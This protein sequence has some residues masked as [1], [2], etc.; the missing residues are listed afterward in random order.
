MLGPPS[1]GRP[2]PSTDSVLEV[3]RDRERDLLTPRAPDHLDA[4]RQ[5]LR[6]STGWNDDAWLA[7]KGERERVVE[8]RVEAFSMEVR[9]AGAGRTHD[10]IERSH[11]REHARSKAVP[12]GEQSDGLP[13]RQ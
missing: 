2:A 7:R 10:D 4:D 3:S 13:A 6:R 12:I 1:D 9:R 11:E 8:H 5:A